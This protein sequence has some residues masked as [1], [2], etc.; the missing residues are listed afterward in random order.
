MHWQ[1]TRERFPV[2]GVAQALGAMEIRL[3]IPAAESVIN[4]PLPAPVGPDTWFQQ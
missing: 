1:R 3:G 2:H 4:Q